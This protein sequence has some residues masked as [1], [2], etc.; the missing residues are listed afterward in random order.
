[1]AEISRQIQGLIKEQTRYRGFQSSVDNL[2]KTVDQLIQKHFKQQEQNQ[3]LNS[4]PPDQRQAYDSRQQ[5][6][7]QLETMIGDALKKLAPEMFKDQLGVIEKVGKQLSTQDYFRELGE[8]AGDMQDELLPLYKQ[9]YTEKQRDLN[10]GDP[11]KAEAADAWLERAEK[12]P[13]FLVLQAMNLHRRMPEEQRAKLNQARQ[14]N[15]TEISSQMPNRGGAPR[16]PGSLK[17][18]TEAQM[19]KMAIENPEQWKKMLAAHNAGKSGA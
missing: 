8:H 2:P 7:Q 9:L 13:S 3:Y 10:S 6:M 15:S 17:G 11:D 12:N 5:G 4:L 18:L 19:E 1:M 16:A 14:Q